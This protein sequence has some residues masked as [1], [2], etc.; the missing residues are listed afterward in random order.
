MHV[1][2][3]HLPLCEYFLGMQLLFHV[4]ETKLAFD[5]G[6]AFAKPP[7]CGDSWGFKQCL[8]SL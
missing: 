6:L 4:E 1:R 8:S 2:N 5:V 3:K 7:S